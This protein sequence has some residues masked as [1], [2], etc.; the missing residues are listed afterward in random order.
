MKAE[1]IFKL[2]AMTAA[3]LALTGCAFHLT[4]AP[5]NEGD[6]AP[7]P[8]EWL[9]A[10]AGSPVIHARSVLNCTVTVDGMEV[11]FSADLDSLD[12]NTMSY[13]S[14]RAAASLPDTSLNKDYAAYT[15]T[16]GNITTTYQFDPD[17]EKEGQWVKY[18]RSPAASPVRELLSP[19]ALDNIE[20]SSDSDK[21]LVIITAKLRPE[22]F[23]AV[24]GG[25]FGE[26]EIPADVTCV[27]GADGSLKGIELKAE[28]CIIDDDSGS[29]EIDNLVCQITTLPADKDEVSFDSNAKDAI[30]TNVHGKLYP[31]MIRDAGAGRTDDGDSEEV[32]EEGSGS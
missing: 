19:E 1:T 26:N 13:T 28:D 24:L 15:E 23:P 9:E 4:T 21:N 12:V 22:S 32:S 25:I 6:N 14:G 7:V 10:A 16:V 2:A 11:P 27:L 31:R 8:E 20:L 3:C 17:A 29:M 30:D 5:E 18:S